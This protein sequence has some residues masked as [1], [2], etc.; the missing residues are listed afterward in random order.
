MSVTFD[1][2]DSTYAT[3][4]ASVWDHNSPY[5]VTMWV[6]PNTFTVNR[7]PWM[8]HL[9][10]GNDNQADWFRT[11]ITDATV[12]IAVSNTSYG[13]INSSPTTV[14]AGVWVFLAFVRTSVTNADL[15]IG[16]TTRNTFITKDVTGRGTAATLD[17]GTYSTH[18]TYTWDGSMT[19]FRVWQT[20]LTDGEIVAE[21]NSATVVKT[22]NLWANWIL[23]NSSDNA[24]HSGNSRDL[25][26]AGG[27]TTG[28]DDPSQGGGGSGFMWLYS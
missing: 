20:A 5:T 28:A 6:K 22:A 21:M 11:K 17:V 13:A 8:I 9:T 27:I 16:G 12:D 18:A 24:D 3:R 19:Q 26:F 2:A 14:S 4:T 7:T 15:W 10:G 1:G 23:A 25:T